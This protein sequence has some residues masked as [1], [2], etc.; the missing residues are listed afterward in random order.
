MDLE[1]LG[2]EELKVH[3]EL[4]ALRYMNMLLDDICG[5]RERDKTSGQSKG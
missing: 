2:K 1:K 3:A 4:S 5:Y